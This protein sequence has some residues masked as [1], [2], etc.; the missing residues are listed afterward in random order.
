M[1]LVFM[2][3]GLGSFGRSLIF[4]GLRSY[5]KESYVILY[6]MGGMVYSIIWNYVSM[7]EELYTQKMLDDMIIS[8]LEGLN[9]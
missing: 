6:S 7:E 1:H 5:H 2:Q 8:K 3:V 4:R 9:N